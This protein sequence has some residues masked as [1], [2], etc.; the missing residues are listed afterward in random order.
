MKRKYTLQPSPHDSR[1]IIFKLDR[2]IT[3]LPP[4]FDLSPNMPPVLDQGSLGSCV[5]NATS[6]CL[7]YLLRKEKKTEFQPSRLFI[8]YNT[9]VLIENKDEND[10]CGVCI[11]DVCK[12]LSKYFACGERL[13]PYDINK[14]NVKPSNDAYAK[15]KEHSTIK[16]F[17]VPQNLISIKSTISHGT[18]IIIGIQVYESFESDEMTKTGI[19]SLPKENESCFGGHAILL[20]GYDDRKKMFKCMNSWGLN[21]GQHG[22]FQIPY[23]YVLNPAYANDFWAI[24]LFL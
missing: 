11:R 22:F 19:L 2:S 5:S 24:E 23:D 21:W 6:N 20:V 12:A 1:D 14:F 17:S 8:Y 18:P 16:Y 9:R 7:R 13:W 10:D 4:V 15:A 3:Q